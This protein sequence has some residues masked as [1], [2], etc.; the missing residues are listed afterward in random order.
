MHLF[1]RDRDPN[2]YKFTYLVIAHWDVT[3]CQG[4]FDQHKFVRVYLLMRYDVFN[5]F[6]QSEKVLRHCLCIY[7]LSHLIE[8]DLWIE[9]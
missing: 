7:Y 3:F 1:Q 4:T 2:L 5:N 6:F 9:G 8:K